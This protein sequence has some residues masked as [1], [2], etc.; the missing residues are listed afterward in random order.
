MSRTA[1][2]AVVLNLLALGPLVPAVH[3]QAA[4]PA[5][6]P[7]LS[8]EAQLAFLTSARV[9]STRQIGKGITGALPVV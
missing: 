8:V 6:A 2:V 4:A 3:A 1:V 9:V 5:A 7:A